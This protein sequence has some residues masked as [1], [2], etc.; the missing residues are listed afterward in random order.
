MQGISRVTGNPLS[1]DEH[2]QQSIADILTTPIG[3][4][5]MRREY[6]FDFSVIASPQSQSTIMKLYVSVVRSLLKWE[7]R[8]TI[9]RL[10][11]NRDAGGK[12]T[13]DITA[14]KNN[15]LINITSPVG[16]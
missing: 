3:S 13:L 11:T 6:G 9:T 4:R 16:A 7:P 15:R 14:K 8:I 12:L 2:L 10:Q 1:G 5:V